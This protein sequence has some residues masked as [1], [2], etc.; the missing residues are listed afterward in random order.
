MNIINKENLY[1]L[2]IQIPKGRVTSYKI[3]AEKM[4][5]KAYRAVGKIIGKNRDFINIPCHRVVNHNSN[6]G[7]Y[8]LGVEKKITLLKQEGII[9]KDYKIQN[10]QQKIYLF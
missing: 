9:I 7:G 2:L 1:Q 3:I 4:G 10:F 8:A 6:I 5:I